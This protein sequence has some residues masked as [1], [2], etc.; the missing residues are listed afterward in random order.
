MSPKRLPV[1]RHLPTCPVAAFPRTPSGAAVTGAALELPQLRE[2]A[3]RREALRWAQLELVAGEATSPPPAPRPE[4]GSD[5]PPGS[6]SLSKAPSGP[7]VGF[8]APW[9]S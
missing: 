5:Q 4:L 9:R 3:D 2:L 7:R 6:S 1:A 8:P